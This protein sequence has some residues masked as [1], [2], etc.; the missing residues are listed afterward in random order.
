[1]EDKALCVWFKRKVHYNWATLN[2][3][4][5]EFASAMMVWEGPLHLLNEMVT[6][7]FFFGKVVPC[8][9]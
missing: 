3:K 4:S 5:K 6:S 7:P 8:A 9:H 1:M 2:L